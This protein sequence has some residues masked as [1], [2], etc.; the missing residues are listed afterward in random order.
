MPLIQGYSQKSISS[1]ISKMRK[2]G[3]PQ[4]QAVAIAMDTANRA[5]KKNIRRR[6]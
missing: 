6:G 1:N 3:K 2:E 5:R 4:A